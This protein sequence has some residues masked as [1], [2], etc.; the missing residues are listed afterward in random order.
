[1]TSCQDEFMLQNMMIFDSRRYDEDLMTDKNT[2]E[3]LPGVL[4]SNTLHSICYC[5]T[6]SWNLQ[7]NG[8]KQA[9]GRLFLSW[10]SASI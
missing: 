6:N 1:M 3:Q 10:S 5:W 7:R 2:K 4:G 9:I 8:K